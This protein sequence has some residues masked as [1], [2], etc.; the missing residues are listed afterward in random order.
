MVVVELLVALE[1][2]LNRNVQPELGVGETERVVLG[3]VSV[4]AHPQ[5]LGWTDLDSSELDWTGPKDGFRL[6]IVRMSN[7]ELLILDQRI[8][9]SR[10]L[11]PKVLSGR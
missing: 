1:S 6:F 8:S 10:Q 4:L 3:T 9:K 11:R 2:P 5:K 7:L